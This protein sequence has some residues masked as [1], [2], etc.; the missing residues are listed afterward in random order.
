MR[1]SYHQGESED[2]GVYQPERT[3]PM[4]IRSGTKRNPKSDFVAASAMIRPVA[5]KSPKS[6]TIGMMKTAIFG[7]TESNFQKPPKSWNMSER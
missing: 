5:M 4:I 6:A 1:E 7:S 2:M 3:I